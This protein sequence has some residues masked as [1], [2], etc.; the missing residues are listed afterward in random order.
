MKHTPPRPLSGLSLRQKL[1]LLLS[2][3]AGAVLVA[4]VGLAYGEVRQAA[5]ASAALRLDRIADQLGD[6]S[7]TSARAR[8]AMIAAQ[9]EEPAIRN[10]LGGRLGDSLAL[11]E[12]LEELRV[13]SDGD[14]PVQLIDGNRQLA[15]QAGKP[16]AETVPAELLDSLPHYG[17]FLPTDGEVRYWTVVPLRSGSRVQGWIAQ[18]RRIGGAAQSQALQDLIGGDSRVLLAHVDQPLWVTLAGEVEPAPL[19]PRDFEDA[20]SFRRSDGQEYLGRAIALEGLPWYVI[21]ESPLSQVLARP[22]AFLQRMLTIGLGVIL[23]AMAVA[24]LASRRLTRPIRELVV[25][26]DLIA[27]GD[28]SK[29][30]STE[31]GDE[32][33]RLASAFNVMTE[34][35]SRSHQQLNERYREAQSLAARLE[36][37]NVWAEKSREDALAAN[38]AK[39]DFLATMSHEI[40]T[41]I[42]AVIGYADLLEMGIPG[43]V[44][45]QQ[46]GYLERIKRASQLLIGLVNDVLDFAKLESGR[47]S[48][49]PGIS[50]A[51]GALGSA[52]AVLEPEAER[53]GLSLVIEC[54]EGAAYLGDPQRVEQ[55]LMNLLSNAIKFTARG[56]TVRV[57]CR[58]ADAP[59]RG[60]ALEGWAGSWL[61]IDVEDTGTGIKPEQIRQIFEPFV[62]GESGYTREQGGTGLGL[63]I[64]R[65]LA[66]MMGGALTV[67]S[68]WGEGSCFT[69]WLR[70]AEAEAHVEREVEVG[71]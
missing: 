64:S 37:A 62:Q 54:Q 71:D 18:L 23:I 21:V 15:G 16:S 5:L 36:E 39:S 42:N 48:V 19:S 63:S 70:A 65:S 50:S 22:R 66:G 60:M 8:Q 4:T 31:R 43:P 51:T 59:P 25:A 7:A 14:L 38:K 9:A 12:A 10:A 55:I 44:T 52:T 67:E 61:R 13:S 24:W 35:V 1:T 46:L 58:I 26:T 27:Q 34:Q 47:M 69:L 56:G 2:G 30:V 3:L 41:P 32:F 53:K 20:F 45:E 68:V 28:Y 33:G 29:R 40:R 57:G 6:L 17:P 49:R 11:A